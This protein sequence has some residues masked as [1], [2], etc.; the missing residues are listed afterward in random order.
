MKNIKIIIITG[1]FI[2]FNINNLHSKNKDN[3]HTKKYITKNRCLWKNEKT[4]SKNKSIC[5]Q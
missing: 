1:F 3:E 4:N 5:K 2:A